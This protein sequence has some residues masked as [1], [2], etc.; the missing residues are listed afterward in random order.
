MPSPYANAGEETHAIALASSTTPDGH[1][2][3]HFRTFFG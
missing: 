2:G 1:V 3:A